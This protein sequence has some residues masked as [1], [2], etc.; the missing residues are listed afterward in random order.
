MAKS[1]VQHASVDAGNGNVN[2]LLHKA[3]GSDEHVYFPSIRAVVTGDTLGLGDFEASYRYYDY[4]GFRYATGEDVI[5]IPNRGIERNLGANRYG[6]EMHQF[7]VTVALARLGV[8]SG[9]V[10]LT[11]FAPP[12][13]IGDVKQKMID[14]F[15]DNPAR[16]Q[17]NDDS[18]VRSWKYRNIYVLPEGAGAVLA[19]ALDA[20]G[21]KTDD[22]GVLSGRV[23]VLDVGA[24]TVDALLVHNGNINAGDL[25]TASWRKAGVQ[26]KMIKPMLSQL[27]AR[28]GD[29][30]ALTREM[31]D[32]GIRQGLLTGDYNVSVGA[33]AVDLEKP[34]ATLSE[35]FAGQ[36]I[37][38]VIED[39][40]DGLTNI[41]SV[42]LI[43]GGS[44][45]IE[46]HLRDAYGDKILNPSAFDATKDIHPV[47]MN[48]AGGLRWNLYRAKGC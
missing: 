29:F 15:T 4:F 16:I 38:G 24:Y 8:S 42:I 48:A 40:F 5:D 19:Y 33:S 10:D 41:R 34:V 18:K 26:E 37:N 27:Q 45:L 3:R 36:I 31:L 32:R 6:S 7:L 43:G 14:N 39:T 9:D 35:R 22:A 11:L 30:T 21:D 28:G 46:D 2:A 25:K 20:K 12:G 17:A 47:D 13:L 23:L 44:V 1:K